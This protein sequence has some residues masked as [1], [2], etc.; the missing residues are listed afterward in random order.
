MTHKDVLRR[1]PQQ[2]RAV[3][4]V[5]H[6]LATALTVLD[7]VGIDG[8]N[9]NLLAERAGVRI[10]T[11]YRYFPNKIAVIS[12]LARRMMA[13]WDGWFGEVAGLA[14]PATDWREIWRGLLA[15]YVEGIGALPGGR[16]I[17]HA[18]HAIPEL[19]AID[20]EDNAR[21]A[22]RVA[23]VLQARVPL[24]GAEEASLV[25]RTLLESATAVIDTALADPPR[26]RALVAELERMQLAYLALVIE[27]TSPARPDE[28]RSG[29]AP[30]A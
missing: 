27:G 9:T 1:S 19:R 6:L 29:P 24:L 12:E 21:L 2:Q 10:R 26:A 3:D 14:D 4:T 28:R 15:A 13:E 7:E 5:E 22:D 8:F 30:R 25:G 17:R 23:A 20:Q 16:A 18:V 11:V